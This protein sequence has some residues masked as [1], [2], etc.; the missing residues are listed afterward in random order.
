ME[1][2]TSASDMCD[3]VVKSVEFIELHLEE[4][5]VP[6]SAAGEGDT[7]HTGWPSDFL[8]M[9]I[10]LAMKTNISGSPDRDANNL[11]EAALLP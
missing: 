10:F 9:T 4:M 11:A 1:G 8:P 6:A 3:H 2:V 5:M 7:C